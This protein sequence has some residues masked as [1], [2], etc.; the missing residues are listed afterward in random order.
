MSRV[1][2]KRE[3]L[4]LY[5]IFGLL[6]ASLIFKFVVYPFWQNN[7][8]LN[9]EIA[10]TKLKLIKYLEV[11]NR[12]DALDKYPD[13]SPGLTALQHK[14]D[15]PVAI[16]AELEHIS[17]KTN[18]KILDIRPQTI[19]RASRIKEISFDLRTEADIESYLNFIYEIENSIFLLKIKK[20]LLRA[21]AV[22]AFLEGAFTIM[23]TSSD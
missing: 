2:K 12:R 21:T 17:Q 5:I 20:I 4:L 1:L 19:T 18:V 8:S 9:K 10:R 13:S 16:L 14:G 23:Q 15:S 11:L 7:Q 3:Q 22:S 6:S